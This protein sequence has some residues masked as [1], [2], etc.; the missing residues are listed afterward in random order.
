MSE[1][2][3]LKNKLEQA[4]ASAQ[5]PVR[6]TDAEFAV[7]KMHD[8][9]IAAQARPP[10]VIAP[11]LSLFVPLSRSSCSRCCP[12]VWPPCLRQSTDAIRLF[13]ESQIGS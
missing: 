7:R 11:R 3:K 6:V 5:R 12:I 1:A 13:L 2:D 8:A 4:E 9:F 10:A